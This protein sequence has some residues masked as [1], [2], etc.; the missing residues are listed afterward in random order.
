MTIVGAA[1]S[2]YNGRL[3]E[4]WRKR[5]ENKEL[6]NDAHGDIS[7]IKEL[8]EETREVALDNNERLGD[9][10]N[11]FD[12]RFDRMETTVAYLHTDEVREDPLLRGRLDVEADDD[13]LSD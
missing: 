4:A 12:E 10:E 9:V 11:R 6:A 7:E 2:F 5:K 8:V 3:G 1:K 13:V